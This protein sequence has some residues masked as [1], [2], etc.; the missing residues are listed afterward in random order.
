MRKGQTAKVAKVL[1]YGKGATTKINLKMPRRNMSENE[2]GFQRQTCARK[3][4]KVEWMEVPS[5]EGGITWLEL[6]VWYTMHG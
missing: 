1:Q 5:E 6:Y 3:F 2:V 4:L